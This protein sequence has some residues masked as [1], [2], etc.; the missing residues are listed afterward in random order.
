MEKIL[1]DIRRLRREYLSSL[2]QDKRYRRFLSWA[3]K[4]RDIPTDKKERLK[5]LLS[6]VPLEPF[7]IVFKDEKGE[8][9]QEE[10]EKVLFHWRS[11]TYW[12]YNIF[13]LSSGRILATWDRCPFVEEIG[14]PGLFHL[15]EGD[16]LHSQTRKV[17]YKAYLQNLKLLEPIPARFRDL[18]LSGSTGS[19]ETPQERI[20]AFYEKLLFKRFPRTIEIIRDILEGK[21]PF[22]VSLLE[23]LSYEEHETTE[24][25]SSLWK[26]VRAFLRNTCLLDEP[27]EIFDISLRDI[28]L[29]FWLE[30]EKRAESLKKEVLNRFGFEEIWRGWR[31]GR[32]SI[33]REGDIEILDRRVCIVPQNRDLPL[34]DIIANKILFLSSEAR[35]KIPT[36]AWDQME[37][38][39]RIFPIEKKGGSGDKDPTHNR[40]R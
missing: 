12:T 9:I 38:L 23:I 28:F 10:F 24:L 3:E 15:E 2:P 5:S 1:E 40:S 8:L 27:K 39:E 11:E 34:P 32:L 4:R 29:R 25:E 30:A 7:K 16:Y 36:I 26:A 19:F 31:K 21:D 17:F 22:K 14:I 20:I 6:E 33:T 37:E 35:Y 13:L 18:L